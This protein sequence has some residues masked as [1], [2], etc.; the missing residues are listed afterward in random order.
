MKEVL[1]HTVDTALRTTDSHN[2]SSENDQERLLD[3]AIRENMQTTER[4]AEALMQYRSDDHRARGMR[5][6]KT[7]LPEVD[8]RSS[9]LMFEQPNR[10]MN[11]WVVDQPENLMNQGPP[12]YSPVLGK[13]IRESF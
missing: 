12:N 7:V 13:S 4:D 9:P 3:K 10:V 6:K 11:R 2:D 8:V 5:S 1:Q